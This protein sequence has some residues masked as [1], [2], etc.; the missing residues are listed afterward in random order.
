MLRLLLILVLTSPLLGVLPAGGATMPLRAGAVLRP[1]SDNVAIRPDSKVVTVGESFTLNVAIEGSDPVV[2]ADVQITFD[3]AY[4]EV[5][6]VT[7]S[8]VFDSYFVNQS[9]LAA[10]LIWVG[11]GTYS[12][13]TPP[14]T[15]FT[16]SV[17]AKS[18]PG[19]TT[20]AFNPAETD[21]QGVSGSVRGS[22]INGSVEIRPV[23]TSTPTST[24]SQT[25]TVTLTPTQTRTPTITPTPT[26]TPSQ[27]PTA[28]LAP[29]QTQTPTIAP[30]LTSTP[31]QTPTATLTPTQTRT[32]TITPTPTQTHTP[33]ITPTPSN[34][35]TATSTPTPEPGQLCVLAFDDLN[36]NW[37]RDTGELL[38]SGARITIRDVA[39]VQVAQHTTDGIR[40]PKCFALAPGAH[41]LDE[42]DP[43][44]YTSR[45]PNWWAVVIA[46]QTS[47]TVAFADERVSGTLTPT[48][49]TTPPVGPTATPR[50][51]QHRR[52]RQAQH[53]R[54]RPLPRS[55]RRLQPVSP[56][57]SL[58]RPL[59]RQRRVRLR[60]LP[61]RRP[62]HR[63]P[64]P[65][66]PRAGHRPLLR[67]RGSIYL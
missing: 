6:S 53:R 55:A 58:A 34:T 11:G 7:N 21:V 50:Q 42:I 12:T 15:F 19:T 38:L 8:G 59:P 10:G 66:Q 26:S 23:P 20:L 25:P 52:P 62:I 40:E 46:S 47:L 14:F 22:L 4:L 30:T 29:T 61:L 36:G 64:H 57:T 49:T 28:T 51:A 3:T 37:L 45:A 13:R 17:R 44:G 41:Y 67:V 48:V 16:L 65:Q 60:G 33:T 27:T 32:P 39:F 1:F 56:Q 63:G 5:T 24:P 18:V 43:P 2:A 35:P 31:S 54:L 9:N